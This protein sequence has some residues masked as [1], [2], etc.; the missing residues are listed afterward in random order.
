MDAI[1]AILSR[2]SIRRYKDTPVPEEYIREV[3]KA[4]MNA[5]SAANQQP[6][7]FIIIS[8]RDL[9]DAIPDI[10]PYSKML[11]EA[12]L[13]ILVCADIDREM[14]KTLS[15]G[16]FV[17]DC[18]AATENILI[19]AYALGLGSVWLGVYP[20]EERITAL[21]KML[22]LP[23]NIIPFS[24]IALGFSDE[25]KEDVLRYDEARIHY[26]KW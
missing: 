24:L 15:I 6:W 17:Q 3:L 2:R 14:F 16:Y 12:P 19:A 20:V 26:N 18:S 22:N 9:L 23:L 1:K 13:A 5:P 21:R 4:G 11:K 8:D 25:E 10:H 7:E